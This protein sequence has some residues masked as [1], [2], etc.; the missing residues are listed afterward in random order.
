MKKLLLFACLF[1]SLQ[2]F[3]VW[4]VVKGSGAAKT[5]QR[6]ASGYTG[7]SSGGPISVD[8]S[9]GESNSIDVEADDNILP[10]IETKVKDGK[11][12]IKV[13][14]MITIKPEVP[15]KVHVSMK[16]INS[17]AQSGSGSITGRG[18]FTNDGQT[19]FNVS[20]SGNINLSFAKFHETDIRMSGSGAIELE[21]N[22]VQNLTVSQSGS[23]RINCIKAP[24]ENVTAKVSGSGNIKVNAT[25]AISAHISGSGR[26]L[27]TG[28]ATQIDTKVS[29]SGGIEKI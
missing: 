9:Y 10:Y 21:G 27:Y 16:T 7:I 2:S 17:I 25:K 5:E 13:R 8:I 29:G 11:L 6:D 20:G 24:C 1:G 28:N 12:I 4:K 23:G 15:V 18:G 14:D 3:D 26:I 22:I 19:N